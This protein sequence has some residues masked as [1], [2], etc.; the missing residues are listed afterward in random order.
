MLHE[1]CTKQKQ[2]TGCIQFT[3]WQQVELMEQQQYSVSFVQQYA[4][5]YGVVQCVA[6]RFGGPFCAKKSRATFWPQSAPG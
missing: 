6:D 3:P 2:Q 5:I 1:I 4:L